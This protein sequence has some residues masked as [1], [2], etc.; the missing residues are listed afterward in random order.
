M[1]YKIVHFSEAEFPDSSVIQVQD[2]LSYGDAVY[3]NQ[4]HTL[5]VEHVIESGTTLTIIDGEKI[6]KLEQTN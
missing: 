5:T 2:E 3:V 1:I 6:L 4:E